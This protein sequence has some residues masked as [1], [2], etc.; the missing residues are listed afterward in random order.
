MKPKA[1][2]TPCHPRYL[3]IEGVQLKIMMKLPD[4][5]QKY[6]VL[7]SQYTTQFVKGV[8]ARGYFSG[9]KKNLGFVEF[10]PPPPLLND[11]DNFTTFPTPHI[12]STKVF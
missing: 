7:Q 10:Y 4:I 1:L 2:H 12:R 8:E 11:L 9:R 3:H 5:A 6:V